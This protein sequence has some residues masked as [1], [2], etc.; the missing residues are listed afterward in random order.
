MPSLLFLG[1][2][3]PLPTL[4]NLAEQQM[5]LIG[6]Y[7]AGNYALPSRSEMEATI[8]REERQY[9]GHFYDSARHRMQI[10]FNKYVWDLGRERRRG[11]RRR[12]QP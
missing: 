7:L 2:A 10:D 9:L 12:R 4:V 6:D 1:L 5:K 8:V 11:G 3:Q